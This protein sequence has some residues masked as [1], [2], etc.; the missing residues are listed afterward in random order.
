MTMIEKILKIRN[1]YFWQGRDKNEI[2]EEILKQLEGLIES[3]MWLP[4]DL[5]IFD[6]I[7]GIKYKYETKKGW[8][9]LSYRQLRNI[10]VRVI[11]TGRIPK[12]P[13]RVCNTKDFEL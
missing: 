5:I 13:C 3:R 6:K 8:Q 4:N 1:D 2:Y 12:N 7:V 9:G 10:V 11:K